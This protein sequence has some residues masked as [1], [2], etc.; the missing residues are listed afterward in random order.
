MLRRHVNRWR[1]EV[2]TLRARIDRE[3]EEDSA[4]RSGVTLESIKAERAAGRRFLRKA[5]RTASDEDRR[6]VWTYSLVE[7]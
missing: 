5:L 4:E 6:E 2:W 7:S 1:A 3:K